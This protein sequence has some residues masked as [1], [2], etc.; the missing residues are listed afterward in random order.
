MVEVFDT[1][2]SW[3]VTL[4]SSKNDRQLQ[5][6]HKMLCRELSSLNWSGFVVLRCLGSSCLH[7]HCYLGISKFWTISDWTEFRLLRPSW[8]SLMS[9][10]MSFALFSFLSA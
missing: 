6:S 1:L 4:G 3:A 5:K 2:A 9:A 10:A 7:A 8:N